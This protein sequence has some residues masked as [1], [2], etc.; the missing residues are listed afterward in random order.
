MFTYNHRLLDRWRGPV[1]SFAV[2]AYDTDSQP[3]GEI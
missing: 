1:A 3:G 2:L